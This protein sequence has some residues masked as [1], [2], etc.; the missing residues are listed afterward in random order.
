VR[1]YWRDVANQATANTTSFVKKHLLYHLI[2]PGIGLLLI[3]W[4]SHGFKEV[5]YV[6]TVSL[7]PA[8]FVLALLYWIWQFCSIPSRRETEART[9]IEE[10]ESKIA[11]QRQETAAEYGLSILQ[12][13]AA[14]DGDRRI[15][16][17]TLINTAAKTFSIRSMKVGTFDLATGGESGFPLPI[18]DIRFNEGITLQPGGHNTFPFEIRDVRGR[19]VL[20]LEV[21][22]HNN[23]RFV[24]PIQDENGLLLISSTL[25]AILTSDKG[26]IAE[27][28]QRGWEIEVQ[29]ADGVERLFD[30]GNA[31][32]PW[33]TYPVAAE[34]ENQIL[35]PVARHICNLLPRCFTLVD[36]RTGIPPTVFFEATEDF[37]AYLENPSVDGL[38]KF[39]EGDLLSREVFGHLST[40]LSRNMTS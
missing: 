18:F 30:C 35:S 19:L 3:I 26:P 13:E 23:Q 5:N 22:I 1:N 28:K 37:R 20:T 6:E 21:V 31:N 38:E 36:R 2:L 4:R 33:F 27:I 10:L 29:G 17:I 7:A 39:Y 14:I 40:Y 15:Y 11:D 16:Q 9:R 34:I 8:A 25:Y 24:F 12:K 32:R